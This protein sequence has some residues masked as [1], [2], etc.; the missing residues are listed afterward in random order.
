MFELKPC[1]VELTGGLELV[2]QRG[3]TVLK[4][5]CRARGADRRTAEM[6][7]IIVDEDVAERI[8]AI[9]IP[10]SQMRIESGYS[11]A[12]S[13]T[14]AGGEPHVGVGLGVEVARVFN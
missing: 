12:L 5:Y 7:F 1:T 2:E 3:A 6:P 9:A 4:G 13:C 11:F 14:G 10:G 8:A